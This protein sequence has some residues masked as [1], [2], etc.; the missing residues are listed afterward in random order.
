MSTAAPAVTEVLDVLVVGAGF[1]GLYQLE[2]LRSRGYSVKVVEAGE[3]L[4]GIWHWN[5]Y[6]GAR[7]DS[8]G[9][10]YQF[11][12]P[13]LWDEFA[14]S[15]LYPGGDELRRY[16]KYVD[17]KLDLSK[18]IYYNTRVISAEFD[19][20]ANTWTVTAE[21][22]S[23]FVCKYFVLCT[24]FA[25]KPIFPKL[26][27]MDSFA[28]INHHTGLWPEG[29]I[30]F[31][32]KRIAIIGTGASGVQVAQ[33]ASKKAAQLTIFQ[34]TPVQALPMRQR[35]LTDE[36]NAKIKFDLA[37]R[38]S[39]R[40]ASFSGFDF[41]FIP[42]SALE[43]S[44]EERITTYERLWECGFEFWLGTY[45]D[46]FVDDDANDT[47]YEFWR[48]RTRARINDPVIAEKLAPM[49]KAYPFGVKRPS[50]EQTYYDI[51]NQDNVRLVDLHEDPIETITPTGLKT[52]SEEHEFD[53][54]VYAT[55]FDAVTGG[56]TAID[57]RGT[58]GTLLR[59]K[60]SNGVR[61]NLG[62]ATA[63]FP[64]LLFLYGPLSPSGFC[65]GPSCA[66]IQ[67]DLV[68]NTIDYMRDNG[69]NRIESEAD[70]DAAW[71]DH[72]AELTAEALYDKADS[73]YMGANVPGKPRQLLNY[74]GGLP[75]YL[76]KWDETVCAGYKGFTLS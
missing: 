10:I 12:R 72:V 51:F 42:K 35:Q 30:E 63:G 38:F 46:V 70:A 41:D 2:N 56:L 27:G 73:W 4:G 40:S 44:E 18:D 34:R 50:L 37:D 53:I 15:E 14:F 47:A 49:K 75:L 7:V 36:D 32:G 43:V 52:T 1:A 39:R 17:A 19:D 54:I 74:P 71:S 64:N 69:L 13:D 11:T 65:N 58:D 31:A 66:E 5:R 48:D 62:V 3:G 24:G 9:P 20:T 60:W 21:N 26:P 23:T 55:G 25:A 67:G 61:A 22:G 16:F 8:E 6:P 76:A 57:I 68:V 29:G 59:D 45:Q 33:E 28:G